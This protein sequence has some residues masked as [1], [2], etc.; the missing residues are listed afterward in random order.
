MCFCRHILNFARRHE[1]MLS[2]PGNRY[3]AM[4][5][6]Q[7]ADAMVLVSALVRGITP[8]DVRHFEY[9]QG[10]ECLSNAHWLGP[11]HH[12]DDEL[13]LRQNHRKN[14]EVGLLI[15]SI[16]YLYSVTELYS[17]CKFS[18]FNSHPRLTRA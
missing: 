8:L 15:V 11:S 3:H 9:F 7:N 16:L 12:F 13:R 6:H 5:H 2:R 17:S 10:G 1:K 18:L 4:I 14:Q